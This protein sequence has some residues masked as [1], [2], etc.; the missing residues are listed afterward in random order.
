LT[1]AFPVP[2]DTSVANAARI[3]DYFLGGKDHF[4]VDRAA[5]EEMVSVLPG[6]IGACRDNRAFLQRAVRFLAGG[7]GMRQFID[8]GTGLPTMGSVHQIAQD[9]A[10]DCRVA[11]VDYDMTVLAHARALLADSPTVTVVDGDLR[12]PALVLAD[13]GLRGLID[14]SQPVA[15]LLVAVLHFLADADQPYESVRTLMGALPPG[16]HLVVSHST[17]DDV[18]PDVTKAMIS[19]YDSASAQVT[20]RQLAGVMRFFD[21]LDLVEPGIV[22]VADWRPDPGQA[23]SPQAESQ[24]LVYGGIGRKP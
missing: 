22:N 2:V 10:P 1:A 13:E 6:I 11:Y 5:A 17:P 15:L 4:A 20:P 7:A 18:P 16:S 23:S 12:S 14:F 8:I 19:V 21:G 24:S 9:I 3:Y